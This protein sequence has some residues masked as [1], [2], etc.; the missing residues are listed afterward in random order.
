MTV[1]PGGTWRY[2][3]TDKEGKQFAFHGVYHDVVINE[4][5]VYTSEFE[6]NPGNVTLCTE[7]LI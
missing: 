2:V 4:Q 5:P 3:Q 1:M 6:G 7:T